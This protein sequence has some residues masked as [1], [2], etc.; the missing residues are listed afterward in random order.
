MN[1]FSLSIKI[2]PGDVLQLSLKAFNIGTVKR[3][4]S[5]EDASGGSQLFIETTALLKGQLEL[6]APFK[7]LNFWVKKI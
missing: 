2:G 4:S 3:V 7:I 1:T 6:Q 5:K